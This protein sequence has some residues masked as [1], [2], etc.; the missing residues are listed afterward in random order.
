MRIRSTGI[1]G[2]V[3]GLAITALTVGGVPAAASPEGPVVQAKQHYVGQYIVKLKDGVAGT[4]TAEASVATSAAL[5]ARYGGKLDATFT[6]TMR[7][8]TVHE[9]SDQGARRLAADP[10]VRAVLEDG[11]AWAAD[12]QPNPTWGLDRVDRR[13][14]AV[15]SKYIYNAT[16]EG[17][18][19]HLI[20][21]GIRKSHQ[22]LAGRASYGPDLLDN[23]A[24]SSDCFGHGSHVGGTI[25][26]K[27][28]GVAKKVKIV[29]IRVLGC[30]GSGPD[31]GIVKAFEWVTTNGVKPAVVNVSIV[32]DVA[33]AGDEQLAASVA[34]GFTYAVAAANN[35][36]ADACGYSPARVPEAITVASI[37]KGT[38]QRSIFSNVGRCVDIFAP[39][40]QILSLSHSSDTGTAN[41][42]GTSITSPHVAG[43][44]AL[45]LQGNKTA[46]PAAVAKALIDSSTKDKVTN[47]GSGSPN[48]ILHTK[49]FTGGGEPEPVCTKQ[50]N[51]NDVAITDNNTAVTSGITFTGC[52]G[53]GSATAQVDVDIKH[54]YRGDL[55]I[56]LIA[57]DGT[58][59]Q[60]KNSSASDA[61]D[62]VIATYSANVS[63]E[64][65]DG[66]WK[67]S[68]R[69]VFRGDTG[70]I[71]G[72][73]LTV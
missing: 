51:A 62:N 11:T 49:E 67:L 12:E 68:V 26:A 18:T 4:A 30:G 35:N 71:D 28:Y 65:R 38:D 5:A 8:F 66:T 19:A 15:D 43:A 39:G 59:Y 53:A 47:A 45:Y 57:P 16:G 60:L 7:G 34:A 42:Q 46:T 69:D 52:G 10:A 25:G 64:A 3:L 32:Q 31:S 17:V 54:T 37:D 48:R 2:A 6:A 36:G 33:G 21:S 9:L 41:N 14:A 22:D 1:T 27:T 63:A 44:A 61:A 23:D 70:K 73:S 13:E 20:D 72:W 24:D 55:V 50:T 56:D 40:N 58:A 29:A